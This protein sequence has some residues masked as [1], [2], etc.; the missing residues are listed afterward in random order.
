MKT[1]KF[2]RI[3]ASLNLNPSLLNDHLTLN[4]NAKGMFART[5]YADTG[6]V[7][8]AVYFDPTQDPYNYTSTYH[9]QMLGDDLHRTLTNF[10]GFFQWLVVA[11]Y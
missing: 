6:A 1:S 4:L 5:K 2:D 10:G 3:T 9:K 8:A 11:D 7:S